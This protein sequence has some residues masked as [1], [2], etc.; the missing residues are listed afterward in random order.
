[1][2]WNESNFDVSQYRWVKEALACKKYAFAA[3]FIRMYVLSRY[4]G[5]YMD[6]DVQLY[7]PVESVITDGFV[8]GLLNHHYGTDFMNKVSPDG[9]VL[10]NHEPCTGFGIQVGFMYS[11]PHHPFVKSFME[12]VYENGQRPFIN[13]DGSFNEL[14]IDGLMMRYLCDEYGAKFIDSTQKL[15]H[16]TTVL[17]LRQERQETRILLL[18]I[19]LTN[20]GWTT[21]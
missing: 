3:D 18:C 4:G 7:A 17:Y 13:E 19:G 1:M 15:S 8:S 21:H 5:I 9:Y 10:D 2:Q 6:T 11:E 12:K 14:V 16:Y 20:R